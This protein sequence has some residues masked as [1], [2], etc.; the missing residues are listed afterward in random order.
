[1][2][3]TRAIGTILA[4]LA[5]IAFAAVPALAGQAS[6]GELFF[7]P[8]TSCHPIPP[9]GAGDLP[10]EFEG[11]EVVL[12]GHDNLGQGSD[13]C[14]ACHDDPSRDPGKLKL[15]DGTLVDMQ[16]GVAQVCYRCHFDKYEEFEAGIHG[17]LQGDCTDAGC[18]DPHTPRQIYA[19][20]LLPFT[21]VGF[22]FTGVAEREAFAPLAPPAPEPLTHTP[23]WFAALA[24]AGVLVA[25]GLIAVMVRGRQR[26]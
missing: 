13:A 15:A 10:I 11:H 3:A 17:H 22:Q 19:T 16:D 9:E 24:S 1:M 12:E 18:H 21:G 6:A 7:Y 8:C 23:T 5:V 2:T 4:T 14:L 25:L 20:P 26:A